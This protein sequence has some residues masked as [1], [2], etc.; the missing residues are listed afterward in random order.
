MLLAK[1]IDAPDVLDLHAPEQRDALGVR[2]VASRNG[3]AKSFAES[4]TG[5]REV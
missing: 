3:R 1:A 5:G 2:A 4:D